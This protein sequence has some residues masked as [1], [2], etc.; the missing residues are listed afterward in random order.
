MKQHASCT[1]KR[2]I[3]LRRTSTWLLAVACSMALHQQAFAQDAQAAPAGTEEAQVKQL[4]AVV[5]TGSRIKRTDVEQA[6]PLD[7]ISRED[8]AKRGVTTAAE[9]V[10]TLTANTAPIS[11][12]MSIT[13]GT[14][15][16]R[17][18]NAANLRG[19]GASST[20][21]LL[22][23]RRAGQ[24]RIARR[25][26]RGRPQRDSRR[27]DRTGRDPEGRRVRRSMARMPSAA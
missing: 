22:N 20:L 8:I 23:G 15:G 16:Q 7:I 10:K 21:I 27:R 25:Q 26:C 5:V 12:G 11:D 17:G 1:T 4:D 14:S 19:I 18:L 9:L 6:L 2:G 13:D 24:L 3:R